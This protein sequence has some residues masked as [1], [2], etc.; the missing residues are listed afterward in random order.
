MKNVLLVS[1]LAAVCGLTACSKESTTTPAVTVTPAAP[2]VKV[3]ITPS[4]PAIMP[5]PATDT[6]IVVTPVE[7]A[8]V[9][10]DIVTPS[11]ESVTVDTLTVTTPDASSVTTI[12]TEET[13]SSTVTK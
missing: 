9:P 2:D 7:N 1:L 12:T 5:A 8:P 3:E 11:T 10:V 13:T 6:V 4:A